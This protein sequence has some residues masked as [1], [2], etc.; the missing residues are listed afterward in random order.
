[1]LLVLQLLALL[2]QVLLLFLML[3]GR[4]PQGVR[5]R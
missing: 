5:Q 2:P 3:L 1:L 4:N